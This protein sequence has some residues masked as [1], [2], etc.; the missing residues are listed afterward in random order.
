MA[1]RTPARLAAQSPRRLRRLGAVARGVHRERPGLPESLRQQDVPCCKLLCYLL[2]KDRNL[3]SPI[4]KSHILEKYPKYCKIYRIPHCRGFF[5]YY[6]P[7]TGPEKVFNIG[8]SG[9]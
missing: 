7:S 2:Q 3:C 8:Y 6:I 1:R 9:G 4:K 5:I